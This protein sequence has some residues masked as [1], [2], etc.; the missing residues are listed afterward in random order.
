MSWSIHR[1]SGRLFSTLLGIG[2]AGLLWLIGMEAAGAAGV[3][4]GRGPAPAWAEVTD[5]D[6]G[7]PVPVEQI[8]RGVYYLLADRQARVIGTDRQQFGRYAMKVVNGQGLEHAGSVDIDYDPAYQRLQLHTLTV[9]REGRSISHLASAQ[10]R[11]LQRERE[12][13]ARVLD[14]T[15]TA[16]IQIP[17]VRVGDVVE[18]AYTLRGARP[19]MQGQHFGGFDMRWR[20]P[21]LRV[22]ARLLW[23]SQRPVLVKG[24][25]MTTAAEGLA[26]GDM[27]QYEWTADKVDGLRLDDNVPAWYDPYPFVQWTSFQDW[28]AVSRWAEP[29]YAVPSMPDG[30]LRKEVER[31]RATY[32]DPGHQALSALQYVQKNIRYLSVA[33]GSGAYKPNPPAV[34]LA[35]RYGDCKDKTLLLLTMLR[36][37]G[38]EARAGLVNTRIREAVS[39]RVASPGAFDHVLVRAEINGRSYWLDPTSDPQVGSIDNISQPY[40]GHALLIDPQTKDLEPMPRGEPTELVRSVHTTFDAS[41]GVGKPARLTVVT[42]LKGKSAERFRNMLASSNLA[43]IG[44][45]YLN[46]Y[47]AYFPGIATVNPLRFEEHPE[48]NAVTV[49]ESYRLDRFWTTGEPPGSLEATV[50]APDMLEVLEAPESRVRSD[51]LRLEYPL[52][53]EQT[54][55]VRLPEDWTVEAKN[56]EIR[57][58]AFLFSDSLT[59]SPRLLKRV[60]RYVSLQD[61]VNVSDL[62]S[63]LAHLKQ[64]RAAIRMTLTHGGAA[65]TQ[66]ASKSGTPLRSGWLMAVY[67]FVVAGACYWLAR[68]IYRYNPPAGGALMAQARPIGGWLVLLGVVLSAQLGL[69]LWEL[70]PYATKVAAAIL[71]QGKAGESSAITWEELVAVGILCVLLTP[72][73]VQLVLFGLRRSSFP[74]VTYWLS[75]IGLASGFATFAM[76]D[77]GAQ[78]DASGWRDVTSCF[79]GIL[80]C[81]YLYKSERARSTFVFR[82]TREQVESKGPTGDNPPAAAI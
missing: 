55:E 6:V 49:V 57:D 64:S 54:V 61:H 19:E 80:W 40:F 14:G 68:K 69:A 24:T 45:R 82:W 20:D 2:F 23:P 74:R 63:Y 73:P 32:A 67:G 60:S 17:D 70:A 65:S 10:I 11:T 42:E 79:G 56:T 33:I 43:D 75:G 71:A 18:Y 46:F 62:E 8:R 34:V 72:Y 22:R 30:E 7:A 5:L 21:I 31:I 36:A 50:K 4:P 38:I 53:V 81:A 26:R 77:W 9:H 29:L 44:R 41:E 35:R 58:T 37:L 39:Q 1:W 15:L 59:T 66:G 48:R 16:S 13:E 47:D 28:G 25:N 76:A 78:L 27:L 51:P 3:L 52:T 12:L